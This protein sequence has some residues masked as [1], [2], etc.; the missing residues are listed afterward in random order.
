MRTITILSITLA[1]LF[2]STLGALAEGKWCAHYGAEGPR[3]AVSIR[4]SNAWPQFQATADI[5]PSADGSGTARS[6]R[7]T[8]LKPVLLVLY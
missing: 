5:V 1:T 8:Q 4:T 7:R 6:V 2:L 3:I